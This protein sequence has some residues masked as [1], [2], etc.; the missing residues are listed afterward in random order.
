MKTSA[1]GVV[2]LALCVL[3]GS[4]SSASAGPLE[5]WVA[6]IEPL[7]VRMMRHLEKRKTALEAERAVFSDER[8]RARSAQRTAMAIHDDYL[9]K[10]NAPAASGWRKTWYREVAAFDIAD[11]YFSAVNADLQKVSDRLRDLQPQK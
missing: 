6:K 8:D 4:P 11:R 10:G 9:A 1:H 2:L 3:L 5:R 7:R